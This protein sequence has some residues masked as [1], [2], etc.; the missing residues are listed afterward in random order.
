MLAFT[1]GMSPGAFAKVKL[2]ADLGFANPEPA[3]VQHGGVSPRDMLVTLLADHVPS[4]D[5][6]VQ[7]PED[8]TRWA[9]E[10]VTEI[11]GTRDGQRLTY[12]LGTLTAIGSLPTGVAPSIVA[13]GLASGR[14][15]GPGVFAPEAIIEPV[16]VFEALAEQ[17]IVTRESD[18]IDPLATNTID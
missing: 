18:E 1:W 17:G 7:E 14:I 12:R 6:F 5:A 9:K 16:P 4:L 10:I 2:L 13:Q 11:R 15:A 8:P 3:D